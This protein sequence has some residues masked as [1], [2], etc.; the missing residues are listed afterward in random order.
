MSVISVGEL[1]IL[2]EVARSARLV[3]VFRAYALENVD[4]RGSM[5]EFLEQSIYRDLRRDN[6]HLLD[7]SMDAIK[8][9]CEILFG[10]EGMSKLDES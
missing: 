3:D 5:S 8:K 9:S 6:R 10:K 4:R 7:V 1:E 2:E